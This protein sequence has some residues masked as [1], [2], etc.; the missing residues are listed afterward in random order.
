MEPSLKWKTFSS[1]VV[2][3]AERC[4]VE[5]VVSLGALLDAVPHTREPGITGHASSQELI[6]RVQWLGVRYYGY[7]GPTAIHSA[8]MHALD[9]KGIAHASMWGH[10][11]HYIDRAPNP[12]VSHALLQ[13]LRTV[14]DLDV[15][16]DQIRKAGEV[17]EAEVTE[18]ISKQ[19]EV[20]TYVERLERRHDAAAV[21]SGDIPS[22]E[23]M[24]SELEEFLRNQRPGDTP[25]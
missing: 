16:L 13:R 6:Q 1:I 8:F 24:V 17:F 15:D 19:P 2:G 4:G 23:A 18:S 21:P 7:K 5:L 10:S 22:P 11:P 9:A 14:V 20:V 25:S 12:I 3:V